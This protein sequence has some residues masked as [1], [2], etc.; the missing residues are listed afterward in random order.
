MSFHLLNKTGQQV[1]VRIVEERGNGLNELDKTI[2]LK[3]G[4]H[5]VLS[6]SGYIGRYKLRVYVDG[7][8]TGVHAIQGAADAKTVTV[9]KLTVNVQHNGIQ[10]NQIS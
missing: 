3:A 10:I 4:C 2:P 6:I 7:R 8:D 5:D 1:N 9:G